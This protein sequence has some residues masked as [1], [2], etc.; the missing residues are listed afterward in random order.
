MQRFALLMSNNMPTLFRP[1]ATASAS[2]STAAKAAEGE[3]NKTRK[4]SKKSTHKAP[5]TKPS[6]LEIPIRLSPELSSFM[7]INM[8]SRVEVQKK[9][10]VFSFSRHSL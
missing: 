5:R 6:G 8:A 7:G 9:V 1:F 3:V 2:V 10:Y 4:S